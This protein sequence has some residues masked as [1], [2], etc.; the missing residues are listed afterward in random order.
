VLRRYLSKVIRYASVSVVATL[1]GLT[2]LGVAV[3]VVGMSAGWANVLA[4]TAG[5]VPSFELN[6]RWVW[7]KGGRRSIRAEV[8]PFAGLSFAELGIS[9]VAVHFAAAWADS[10]GW[11]QGAR[12]ALVM[13]ANLS[14]YGSLWVIQFVLLDRFLFR[15]AASG[16][17]AG[18]QPPQPLS[19]TP[20]SITAAMATMPPQATNRYRRLDP[21]GRCPPLPP[22]HADVTTSTADQPPTVWAGPRS[23]PVWRSSA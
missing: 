5:M 3:G 11:S 20:G 7:G 4:T 13:A 8:I 16:V 19:G 12:T 21:N 18:R 6:R 1:T 22:R 17:A 23:A 2:V 15:A 14:V 10:R 9:T